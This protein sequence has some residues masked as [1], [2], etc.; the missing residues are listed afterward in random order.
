MREI[1]IGQQQPRG[2]MLGEDGRPPTSQVMSQDD[3]H[4]FF[5]FA[6]F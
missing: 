6:V 4:D 5:E 2:V 1:Q 3:V